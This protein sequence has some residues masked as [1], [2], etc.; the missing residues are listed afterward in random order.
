M[1]GVAMSL[2]IALTILM[3]VVFGVA[4]LAAYFIRAHR[5]S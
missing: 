4:E 2:V 5:H 1:K 3:A